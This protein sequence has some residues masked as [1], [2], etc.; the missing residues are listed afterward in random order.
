V[1]QLAYSRQAL[2]A[3]RK[4]PA[5]TAKRV[6]SKMRRY[7]ASPQD[8]AKNVKAL[9]GEPGY[10]RLRVGGWRVVFSENDKRVA[11]VRIAPRGRACD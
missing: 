7:V 6:R 2:K 11:I 4:M 3:L 8:L 5:N 1:K 9:Q 10:F